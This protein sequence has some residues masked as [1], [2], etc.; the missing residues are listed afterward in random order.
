MLQKFEEGALYENAVK[1]IRFDSF[2]T[3][4][5]RNATEEPPRMCVTKES[6][7]AFSMVRT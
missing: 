1:V 2:R 7:L 3:E 5:P 6:P 4:E